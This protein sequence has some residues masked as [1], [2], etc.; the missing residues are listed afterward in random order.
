MASI[1]HPNPDPKNEAERAANRQ[2]A[3]GH[4]RQCG[5]A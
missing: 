3:D 2:D 4:H 5:S 1:K